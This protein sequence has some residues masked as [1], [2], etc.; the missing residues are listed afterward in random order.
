MI[1]NILGGA[2]VKSIS[3]SQYS[4]GG[5]RSTESS[6]STSRVRDSQNSADGTPRAAPK[7]KLQFLHSPSLT[8]T[9]TPSKVSR[10]PAKPI[11]RS[12]EIGDADS[13]IVS[14][15]AVSNS[16]NFGHDRGSIGRRKWDIQKEKSKTKEAN[17]RCNVM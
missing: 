17:G 10:P 4:S 6:P 8:S 12:T 13:N 9:L 7:R 11:T 14:E 15:D 16:S 1:I 5:A 3:F 2:I